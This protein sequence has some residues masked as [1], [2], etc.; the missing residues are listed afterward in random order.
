MSLFGV[1]RTS[2][3]GMAAQADRLGAV[4]DNIA[5]AS[6]T[7]YKRSSIEFSTLVLDSGIQTY[8]SGSVEP[9]IRRAISEQ[10]AF[11]YTKSVTDLA[12]KGEGFFVV[13]D[14]SGQSFL[15]RAGSFV[16]NGEGNLVNAGGY[17]LMAYPLSNGAPSVVAN[18]T[19]TLSPVNIGTLSLQATASNDGSFYTNLDSRAASVAA[20]DL[21][22]ANAAT[23]Q[24]TSKTSITA[25]DNLGNVV[26]LDVY[27]T[28]VSSENWEV[29]VFD[30]AAATPGTGFPYSTG[31]LATTALVFN[32][33]NGQLDPSSAQSIT[34]PVPNGASL[35]LDLSRTSQLAADYTVLEA[36]VNGNAASAV[37][38][39][40]I[41]ADGT[42]F[43]IYENGSRAATYKIPLANV[44]SADNLLSLSGN[45]FQPTQTS[46]DILVGFAEQDSFGSLVSGALE[47]S[48]VD[49]ATELT[50]MIEAEKNYTANS[51]VFQT[52]ADLMD[53]L[54]NLK[55]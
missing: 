46:G 8:E 12:I 35:D 52:G 21:P 14:N 4:S 41:G 40:E 7:G 45:V 25:F 6:T 47:K 43:A 36:Q 44:P 11:S 5:N 24:F 17:T 23:A 18:G 34:I 48:T 53:V 50:I 22:S 2:T 31:A 33:A 15:T 9:N 39:V 30:Q 54:V 3:S 1:M 28:K 20:A 32:P 27:A 13:N 16:K 29:S 42:L 10:G 26:T 55:R 19:S 51:K 49:L 37:D 38:H